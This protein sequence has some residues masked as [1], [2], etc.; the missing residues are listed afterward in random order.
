LLIVFALAFVQ[1]VGRCWDR[2]RV[3]VFRFRVCTSVSPGDGTMAEDVA[4]GIDG[5]TIRRLAKE[6]V[7]IELTPTEVDGLKSLLSAINGEIDK[8]TLKDRGDSVP[9]T[10]F[11]L[12]DWA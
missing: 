7:K 1:I 3:S 10:L 5:E 11:R 12:E 9:E 6:V 4:V 8:V 2:E